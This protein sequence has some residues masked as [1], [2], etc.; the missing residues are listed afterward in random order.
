MKL[1]AGLVDHLDLATRA[2]SKAALLADYFR[3]APN[4]DR[5]AAISL[6]LDDVAFNRL[7]PAMIRELGGGRVD[8]VLFDMSQDF[9]GDL[10]ETTALMWPARA[11]NRERPGLHEVIET[12]TET[13]RADLVEV[14]VAWLDTMEATERRVF[15]KLAGR[16]LGVGVSATVVRHALA[17]LGG[18]P[19]AEI[20]EI[21]HAQ[22]PPYM[23]LFDWLDGRGERPEQTTGLGFRA[24]MLERPLD[25]SE[26]PDLDLSAFSVEW[27]WD[28]PRVQISASAGDR[29]LFSASGDDIS[30]DH[31]E[32][33]KAFGAEGVFDGVLHE[34]GDRSSARVRLLD[35]LVDGSRDIRE[36]PLESRRARLDEVFST[37]DES[38]FIPSER[39]IIDSTE[40][41]ARYHG[42]CRG[43]GALGLVLKRRD[44]RY[45]PGIAADDWLLWERDPL[46][47]DFVLMYLHHR[48]GGRTSEG[49]EATF[50]A[51]REG[52]TGP[53][54]VPVAK[55]AL[56]RSVDPGGDLDNWISEHATKRFGPVTE[57]APS[58][59]VT[60]AFD[61]AQRA[62]RRKAGLVLRA[63]LVTSIDWDKSPV[64][65][66][67]L[68]ALEAWLD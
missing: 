22:K 30:K 63:P 9:V 2:E 58:L 55:T 45:V 56:S 54:L 68:E 13:P 48:V 12:L 51:W 18:V 57:V 32:L 60:L 65:T 47:A 31:P 20:E 27:K 15:L 36:M 38:V 62:P 16:R 59:V 42:D 10:G 19:L 39:L 43:R 33:L 4:P 17:L 44:A 7:S 40:A 8:P 49:A 66:T 52:V 1:F 11:S 61:S 5:G 67:R 14:V 34:S 50:G 23:C 46:E 64:L 29:R 28:G 53:E 21:W 37:L 6:L 41:L 3:H 35:L 25:P 26:V 24:V